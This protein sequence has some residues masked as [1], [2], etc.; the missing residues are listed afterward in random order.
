MN[1]TYLL[2]TLTHVGDEI[3]EGRKKVSNAFGASAK[4]TFHMGASNIFDIVRLDEL[5]GKTGYTG[6]F[7]TGAPGIIRFSLEQPVL[8][9]GDTFRPGIALK[10]LVDGQGS[11]EGAPS[12]NLFATG[13][14]EGQWTYHL[15]GDSSSSGGSVSGSG[16]SSASSTVGASSDVNLDLRRCTNHNFFANPLTTAPGAGLA[17]SSEAS[18]WVLP[19]ISRPK[20]TGQIPLTHA[21]AITV[22]GSAV[23]PPSAISAPYKLLF[24]PSAGVK[25]LFSSTRNGDFRADL[26]RVPIDSLL[27]HILAFDEGSTSGTTIGS[28]V[29]NSPIVASRYG[30]ENLFFRHALV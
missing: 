21:A 8:A 28:L 10:L 22:S 16:T 4:V 29:L 14:P 18:L 25:N 19:A 30:D 23:E 1:P 24:L 27:Y 3:H 17:H 7:Q 9:D 2:Q 20:H 11:K 26:A 15:R 12:V 5:E 13:S 6:L